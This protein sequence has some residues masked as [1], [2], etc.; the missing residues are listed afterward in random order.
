MSNVSN[1]RFCTVYCPVIPVN[2][3]YPGPKQAGPDE[4]LR[5]KR[6]EYFD[7][8]LKYCLNC[9]RCEVACPSNVKIGDI[10]QLARIKYSKKKPALRDIMLANTDF[11][12]TMA[13]AFAPV[14]N[15]TLSLKP[16]KMVMDGV[17]KIDHHRVF[18]SILPRHSRAGSKRM[19][20]LR[21]ITTGS[22]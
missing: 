4:R 21:R 11:V 22:M 6:G 14:V 2:P 19:R 8:A 15:T 1:V 5:L 3:K 9:K 12:G 10:I 17:L 13:S 20:W 7:E 16:V 18:R